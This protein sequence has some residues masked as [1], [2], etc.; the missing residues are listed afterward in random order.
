MLERVVPW[1]SI[2]VS[3]VGHGDDTEIDGIA[4]LEERERG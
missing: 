4:Q 3:P 1:H 2:K